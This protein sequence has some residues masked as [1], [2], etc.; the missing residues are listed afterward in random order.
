MYIMQKGNYE[1]CTAPASNVSS[2]YNFKSSNDIISLIE[3]HGLKHLGT[4]W[5][6]L[7]KNKEQRAGFQKHLMVFGRDHNEGM[8]LLIT[9]GHEAKTALKIDL[10]YY[11]GACANG[12]IV[13]DTVYSARMV[14]TADVSA[15][16][17]LIEEAI[18][19]T[20]VVQEAIASMKQKSCDLEAEKALRKSMMRLRNVDEL[21]EGS[22]GIQRM[23]D[24]GD[25]LWTRFNVTQEYAIKGGFYF[26]RPNP[27]GGFTQRRAK[28]IKSIDAK[29]KINKELWDTALA[30]V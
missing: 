19:K 10:G 11:R 2:R 16:D 24:L 26:K 8:N 3:S 4:S 9:T 1:H 18:G 20:D 29:R 13:G 14:H 7:R 27:T 12:I 17:R 15:F 22:M 6:S 23:E 30:L 5:Q 25:D 28:A 21:V